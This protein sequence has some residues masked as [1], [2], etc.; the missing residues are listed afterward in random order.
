VRQ[1][2]LESD[3]MEGIVALPDQLFNNTGISTYFWILSNRKAPERRG[4]VVLLDA[5]DQWEKMRKSLGDKRKQVS[6][7]QIRHI[8]ALYMNALSVAVDEGHPD[9]T[10]VKIFSTRDFGYHRITVE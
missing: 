3:W 9:H 10:K 6:A 4:K 1:W 7:D 2:S 5:R 8:T